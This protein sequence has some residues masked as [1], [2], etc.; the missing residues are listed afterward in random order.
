MAYA[1][2]KMIHKFS[3]A[4]DFETMDPKMVLSQINELLYEAG[5]GKTSMTGIVSMIDPVTGVMRYASAGHNAPYLVP[6]SA[7]DPRLKTMPGKPAKRHCPLPSR[8]SPLGVFENLEV[9]EHQIALQPGDKVIFYTDGIFE[10]SNSQGAPWG[11]KNFRK[12][13]DAY[14]EAASFEMKQELLASAF[15]HFGGNA[16]IDDITLVI[17]EVNG[18]WRPKSRAA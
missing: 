5:R 1:G 10:C 6:R 18:Y 16:P 2:Y 8:G 9:E 7:T 13:L 11:S 14:A 17:A 3:G 12:T 4:K 15:K